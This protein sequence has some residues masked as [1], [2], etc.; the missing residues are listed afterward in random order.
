MQF[1]FLGQEDPLEEGIV[2]LSS[3]HAWTIPWT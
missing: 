1:E 2:I 3:I